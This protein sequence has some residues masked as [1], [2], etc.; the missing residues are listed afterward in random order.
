M[1]AVTAAAVAAAAATV[2]EVGWVLEV[3]DEAAPTAA[4]R[5]CAGA[6][7][8]RSSSRTLVWEVRRQSL[9][10]FL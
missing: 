3:E 5:R 2:A 8:V 6:P 9:L 4:S 1:S 7:S 10:P